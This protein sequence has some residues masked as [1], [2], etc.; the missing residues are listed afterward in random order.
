MTAEHNGLR[1]RRTWQISALMELMVR[2]ETWFRMTGHHHRTASGL[3]A[4]RVPIRTDRSN[5]V[6]TNRREW[7]CRQRLWFVMAWMTT[8]ASMGWAQGGPAP[9][10]VAR[11]QE[12]SVAA[13]QTFV[14]TVY[15]A[16][17]SA[18]GS[19]VD[20][21]VVEY[22]INEGDRV[23]KGQALC[24][25]LT[26]TIQLQIAAAEADLRL[27]E[28]ELRELQNGSRPEEIAQAKAQMEAL[29]AVKDFTEARHVRAEQLREQGRT[30]TQEQV[31]ETLSKSLEA[32]RTLQ[33]AEQN[34]QLLVQGPREEKI[35]Q[36]EAKVQGQRELVE[37]LKDQRKKHTMIAPFDGYIVREGTEVGEWV[38]RGHVVAEVVLLDEV[39]ILAYVLDSQIDY[40]QR[41]MSV[42]V[43]VPALKQPLFVGE[44][45]H[46]APEADLKSRTFPVK[47]R[48][49]NVVT[50]DGPSLKVGMLARV[51]LPVGPPHVATLVPK[52]AIVFGG[53]K[54]MAYVVREAPPAAAGAGSRAEAAGA[55]P[56]A[57]SK[58]AEPAAGP[59]L[60]A[61]P[62][63]VELG[64][65]LG[66][67]IEVKSDLQPGDRVVTLGNERL[68]PGL[69]II[70]LEEAKGMPEAVAPSGTLPSPAAPSPA[71]TTSPTKD[72]AD[73]SRPE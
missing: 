8:S 34:Y 53:P 6:T 72:S 52:D 12:Q 47:I 45:I 68:R 29:A 63:P 24:Q 7:T 51:T 33:A 41:G 26:E 43:E 70:I 67:W 50:K 32:A 55:K 4:V 3:V 17:R 58:G 2:W 73:G 54:P 28:E 16:K 21:R 13:G 64:V 48:V 71:K 30:I 37:Q 40:V 10:V 39:E 38:T 36:A 23:T 62:V 57:P 22:P 25:L 20:G 61:M 42:R 56:G 14:A 60:L 11:V 46:V 15:P 66:A 9:V 19:A 69:P 5:G 44:V 49:S 18:V 1:S 65:A 27:R 59:M 31:E 35:R